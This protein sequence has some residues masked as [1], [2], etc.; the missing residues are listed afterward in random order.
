MPSSPTNTY[1]AQALASFAQQ[2]HQQSL[3]PSAESICPLEVIHKLVDDYFIFIHPVIPLPLERSFRQDLEARQDIASPRFLALLASMI[4]CMTASFPRQPRHH[5]KAHG[6]E[7]TYRNSMS[8]IDRC[9][10]V[11]TDALGPATHNREYTIDDAI[12]CYLQGLTN[13]YIFQPEPAIM[14]FKDCL[15]IVTS[16]NEQHRKRTSTVQTMMRQSNGDLS[17]GEQQAAQEN[18]LP[19]EF[20]RRMFWN[21][22][23]TVKT[24][25]QLGLT[26]SRLNIPPSTP[27]DPWPPLPNEDDSEY[28]SVQIS[29][30]FEGIQSKMT[31]FN[32]NT[33]IFRSY[34]SISRRELCHGVDELRD[35]D[36]QRKEIVDSLNEVKDIVKNLPPIFKLEKNTNQPNRYY[37]Q[38]VD[39]ELAPSASDSTRPPV[40]MPENRVTLMLDIQ[41]ANIHATQL[42]TRSYLVEKYFTL[43]E[44]SSRYHPTPLSPGSHPTTSGP[45]RTQDAIMSAEY[46]EVL[47]QLLH[48]IST[49]EQIHMEPNGASLI[50]KVR[51]IARTLLGL[52]PARKGSIPNSEHYLSKFIQVLGK[53]ESTMGAMITDNQDDEEYKL[54]Q[55]ADLRD[56][57]SKFLKD[58]GFTGRVTGR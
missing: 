28:T 25:Q 21:L 24:L 39:P 5:L 19:Q 44:E 34:D 14:Y 9:Q 23:V 41:R 20:L 54:R 50:G 16:L 7:N 55:W 11:A 38:H 51:S 31:G 3:R 42:G 17:Q 36:E 29:Q 4:A 27:A 6:L 37:P 13:I 53:L 18:P 26:P 56:A 1:A 33:R 49:I 48:M 52:P 30:P 45:D 8:F 57:Q 43:K 47:D 22:F 35:W 2:H 15:S 12:I 40:A 58:G 10:R 46:Q 32:I